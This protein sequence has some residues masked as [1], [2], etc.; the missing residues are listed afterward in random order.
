MTEVKTQLVPWSTLTHEGHLSRL[1]LLCFGVWLYAADA[2]LVA[3]VMPV[4]VEDIGGIPFL[5]WVYTL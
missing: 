3:T 2:T 1:L 4:A 5:S